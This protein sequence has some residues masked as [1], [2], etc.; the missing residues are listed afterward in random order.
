MQ[1]K[2]QAE[3]LTAFETCPRRYVAGLQQGA[4]VSGVK[5]IGHTLAQGSVVQR[6]VKVNF[7]A[8]Y[9]SVNIFHAQRI[10]S[11]LIVKYCLFIII[12]YYLFTHSKK[13]QRYWILG[14]IMAAVSNVGLGA[15]Y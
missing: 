7:I 14:T 12:D 13:N 8:L 15:I 3:H 2:N 11:F 6:A 10:V 1:S 4:F 9:S 5:N